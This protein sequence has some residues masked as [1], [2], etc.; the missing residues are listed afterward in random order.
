[1]RSTILVS[2]LV[3]SGCVAKVEELDCRADSDDRVV[4]RFVNRYP[5]HTLKVIAVT[6]ECYAQDAATLAPGETVS[7]ITKKGRTW[8]VLDA[9]TKAIYFNGDAPGTETVMV[10]PETD[11]RICSG[12]DGDEI[13]VLFSNKYADKT[14]QVFW[15]DAA[16]NERAMYEL[17]P[18]QSMVQATYTSH[19]FR[20]REVG[21]DHV[22]DTPPLTPL[23]GQFLFPSDGSAPQC[24][25]DGSTPATITI[26]NNSDRDVEVFWVDYGCHEVSV[27]TLHPHDGLSMSTFYTHTFR[28]REP[29]TGTIIASP[30]PVS[31]ANVEV[32]VP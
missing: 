3:F 8:R 27:G 7:F 29:G 10:F 24:S 11:T 5:D 23:D 17:G 19:V 22:F 6:D 18:R 13:K 12:F 21:T 4:F 20:V 25:D 9:D 28:V 15:L 1:M 30:P 32:A 16:C 26:R 31:A 2:L 14:L